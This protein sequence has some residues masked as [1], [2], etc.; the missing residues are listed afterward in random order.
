MLLSFLNKYSLVP[1][2]VFSPSP[3][4]ILIAITSQR[5]KAMHF[6]LVVLLVLV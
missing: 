3:G 6:D 2:K 1:P 5:E 4:F